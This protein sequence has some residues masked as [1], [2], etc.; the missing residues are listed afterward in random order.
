MLIHHFLEN[1][2][3][4]HPAKVAV[5]HDSQ[6]ADYHEIN[7]RADRLARCLCDSGVAKGD[8]IA[9]LFENS[10][11]YI[12][13]Y[14]AVLKAGAAASP[15]NPGLK[16]DGLRHLLNDLEPAAVIAGLKAERLL[17]AADLNTLGIKSLIIKSPK[18]K[19]SGFPSPVLTFEECI[20]APCDGNLKTGIGPSD[21]ASIIYTSG[22]TGKPKGVMLSHRNIV[23]N[24]QAICRYLSITPDDIQMVVLPFFYVMGK[25]LLNTH[26]AAGGTVVINNRFIYPADVV[27]QMIEEQVT[28]FSGVPSTYAYLL[29]R[30]P[31]ANRKEK[32]RALR[33]CSQAGGHMAASIKRILVKALPPH[34][35]VVVMYGATE[36]SARLAYLDPAFLETK[37]ESIGKPIP[38]VS[39]RV[40][41]DMGREVPDGS[42]GEL[43][44]RGPNIMLGYWKD[45][46]ETARVLDQHGYHTGDIGFRDADGFLYVRRRKDGLLKVGGH[47]INPIEIE[48]FLMATELVIECAVVGLPDKLSGRK[49]SALVVPRDEAVDSETLNRLCAGGLPNHKRPADIIMIRSLPKNA[50]GKIDLEKCIE[51]LIRAASPNHIEENLNDVT[52]I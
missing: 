7:A 31:L 28:A 15:L 17:K 47:R 45:P 29:N 6:R 16:P 35:Q 9:L 46:Q 26:F 11:D 1:S 51:W 48:D 43:V 30:S 10:I 40:L 21:L 52:S 44:A 20:A 12:V 32:L 36:A 27:H 42:E 4:R 41:D 24:T 5:V 8:R 22:S 49:L 2:A 14:Y 39:I 13:A 19:W 50:S 37:I 3:A 34:T 33:Y 25:S 23:S 18:Q 38:E